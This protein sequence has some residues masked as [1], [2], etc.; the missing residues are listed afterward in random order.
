MTARATPPDA[1]AQ[2]FDLHDYTYGELKGLLFD[3]GNAIRARERRQ[4]DEA[5]ARIA[6]IAD[7]AGLSLEALLADTPATSERR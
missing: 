1:A 3:V 5:R 6:A 4:L 7:A 2:P